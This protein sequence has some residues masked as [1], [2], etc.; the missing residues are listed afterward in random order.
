MAAENILELG[1]DRAG[2]KAQDLV[3][4]LLRPGNTAP[5]ILDALNLF[6]A[7]RGYDPEERLF[8]H[9]QGYDLIE[10]PGIIPGET[11]KLRENMVLS[12][13]PACSNRYAQAFCC[14][15]YLVT[16]GGG[17]RLQTYPRELVV[18]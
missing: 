15:N 17:V 2:C 16:S 6:L 10:R 12:V 5:E 11:M 3:A 8:S 9:G 4:D 13:H 18:L 1:A 14:D 7:E